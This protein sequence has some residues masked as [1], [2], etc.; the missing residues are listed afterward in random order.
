[1]KSLM[2][3]KGFVAKYFYDIRSGVFVGE[4]INTQ[5]WIIFTAA[6]L[7]SLHLAMIDAVEHHL[8]INAIECLE[9]ELP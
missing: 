6:T 1:M 4:V 9:I 7:A 2:Q 3:Y 5:E 8:A